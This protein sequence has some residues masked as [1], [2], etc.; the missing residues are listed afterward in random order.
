VLQAAPTGF[1]A[2]VTPGGRVVDR[3]GVSE[4]AV[5]H[6]TVEVR[7]GRTW[8]LVVGDWLALGL[9][10]GSLAAGWWW[11]LRRARVD[12]SSSEPATAAG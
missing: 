12:A 10:A 7:T 1:S 4:R 2:I 3:T 9:G 11:E 8:A 6:G 5:L